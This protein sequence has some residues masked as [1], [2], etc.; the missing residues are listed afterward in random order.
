MPAGVGS[1]WTA[2]LL[3]KIPAF[4]L[5]S[6]ATAWRDLACL[7]AVVLKAVR[8]GVQEKRP[9]VPLADEVDQIRQRGSVLDPS[10]I[11]AASGALLLIAAGL[12]AARTS[13]NGWRRARRRP[14]FP[15]IAAGSDAD[16]LSPIVLLAMNT[17]LRRGELLALDCTDI[18]LSARLL[19]LRPES[20]K[21]GKSGK[22]RHVPLNAEAMRPAAMGNPDRRRRLR[23]R[24]CQHQKQ[25]G[26]L[27]RA[28]K[29]QYPHLNPQ[30]PPDPDPGGL[31]SPLTFP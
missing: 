10:G 2:R 6:K 23:V 21:S 31:D 28:A 16:R 27:L 15:E 12:A 1:R 4:G 30:Q 25:L 18:N 5:I 14:L 29:I 3:T 17:G 11:K 19:T 7:R 20:G 24:G 13:A 22:Q 9:T 26:S 8:R